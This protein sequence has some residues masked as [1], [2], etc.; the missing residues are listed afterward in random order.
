MRQEM[1]SA[2]YAPGPMKSAD[3]T[4]RIPSA[5]MQEGVANTT[6]AVKPVARNL[7]RRA[8]LQ[9]RVLV[10][11]SWPTWLPGPCCWLSCFSF[12]VR[13]YCFCWSSKPK[14]NAEGKVIAWENSSRRTWWRWIWRR[15]R[16]RWWLEMHRLTKLRSKRYKVLFQ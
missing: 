11:S 15:W 14:E 6:Q 3:G 8:L 5:A 7:L 4:H 9:A 10:D 12:R 16:R 13:L 1:E 2:T